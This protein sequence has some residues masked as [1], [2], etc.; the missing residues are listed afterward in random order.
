MLLFI[1]NR[2]LRK[3]TTRRRRSTA[4]CW[5]NTSVCPRGR[6]SHTSMRSDVARGVSRDFSSASVLLP[7]A[8]SVAGGQPGGQRAAALLRGL[9]GVRLQG[10]GGPR[11]EDVWLCGACEYFFFFSKQHCSFDSFIWHPC[12]LFSVC[13]H[14]CC[15]SSCF[16]DLFWS[17]QLL[18]FLQGLFTYYHH[19][20]ELA[21][22]FNHFKTELTISIQNVIFSHSRPHARA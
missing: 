10:A 14:S 18:A 2:R 9:P 22:D 13:F 6:R 7:S 19:G 3:N 21:K 17:L 12:K 4:P 16:C 5:R 1:W 20:Y 8:F 11:E 15:L